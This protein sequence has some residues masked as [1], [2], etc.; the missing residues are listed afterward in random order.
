MVWRPR[1]NSR[2][3]ETPDFPL[4]HVLRNANANANVN[5]NVNGNGNGNGNENARC[6]A[7]SGDNPHAHVAFLLLHCHCLSVAPWQGVVW[8][9]FGA[10]QFC[11]GTIYVQVVV[12]VVVVV[13]G[14]VHVG[15]H[16]FLGLELQSSVEFFFS[17]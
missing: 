8:C 6:V 17:Q 2:S 16:A 5:A 12:V 14:C 1:H 4:V 13:V 7:C 3:D 9:A 15:A 11:A 10:I